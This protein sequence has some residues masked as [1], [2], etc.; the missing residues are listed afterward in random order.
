MRST[1]HALGI[2]AALCKA[3]AHPIRGSIMVL[4]DERPRSPSE[5]ADVL[6]ET[7]NTVA[8]HVRELAKPPG[9]GE[10]PLIELV[11][12][13]ER[14]GG[15]RH[16]YKAVARPIIE[17]E[18]WEALAQLVREFNSV[19]VGQIFLGDLR[20]A[21]EARTFDARPGRVMIRMNLVLDEEGWNE[22][23]PAGKAWL[24]SLQDIQANSADRRATSNEQPI[25]VTTGA[26]AFEVPGHRDRLPSTQPVET[27]SP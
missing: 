19:W 12:T 26:L 13:D 9:P 15:T 20:E 22:L 25:H 21:F 23:E 27:P 17:V 3:L 5:I 1:K 2:N 16:I 4:L 18:S 6:D 11:G 7:L 8:Y 24:E 14:R 10:D